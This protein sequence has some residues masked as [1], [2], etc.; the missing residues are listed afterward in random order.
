[1]AH[2]FGFWRLGEEQHPRLS[3]LSRGNVP[4]R[5]EA[6]PCAILVKTPHFLKSWSGYPYLRS[7]EIADTLAN[8]V[9]FLRLALRQTTRTLF[10]F[11]GT[12]RIIPL[13]V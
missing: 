4:T 6:F 13:L 11:Q 12:T 5:V 1:M 8:V 3:T 10:S 7:I 2:N 9:T